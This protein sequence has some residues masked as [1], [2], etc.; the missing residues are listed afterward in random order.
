[1]TTVRLD[2]ST[3]WQRL[4]ARL[5]GQ[6]YDGEALRLYIWRGKFWVLP[7]YNKAR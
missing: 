1:M 6:R 4:C 3:R 5:F 7:G 2:Q